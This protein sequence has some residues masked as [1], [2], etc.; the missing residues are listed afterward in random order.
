MLFKLKTNDQS[1]IIETALANH[2]IVLEKIE[3]RTQL[4]IDKVEK[5]ISS[6]ITDIDTNNY[7]IDLTQLSYE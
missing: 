1:S 2:I 4:T 7:L 5:D 3:P 6:T